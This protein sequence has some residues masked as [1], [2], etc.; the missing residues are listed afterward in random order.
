LL[1][2]GQHID[3]GTGWRL[4]IDN[5]RT[6]IPFMHVLIMAGLDSVSR[7]IRHILNTLFRC[8]E[9]LYACGATLLCHGRHFLILHGGE[10]IR[11]F[12]E[13]S[14]AIERR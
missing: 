8:V 9:T 4:R 14:R 3:P 5:N 12:R 2:F 7:Q 6:K 13:R 11:L 1:A 10:G